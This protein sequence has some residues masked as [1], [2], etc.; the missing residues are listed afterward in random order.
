MTEFYTSVEMIG[1]T[2]YHRGYR[3][4]EVFL[5]K[6]DYRPT[7]YVPATTKTEHRGLDGV[8]LEPFQPG[9]IKDCREF[10]DR[11]K[12]VEGFRVYGNTDYIYPFIGENYKGEVDYD[13]SPVSYTHLTLPTK[14]IV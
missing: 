7:L 11:Y 5:E 6:V 1:N 2:L 13:F 10:I 4:G 9:S 12:Q 14:R 8:Y 3:D